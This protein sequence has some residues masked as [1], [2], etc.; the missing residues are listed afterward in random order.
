M[1]ISNIPM[2][3]IFT[4]EDMQVQE[5]HDRPLYFK[6]YIGSMEITRIQVDPGS[7]LSI[8]PRR[9]MEHLSISAHRLST[10]DPNIF[11][12]MLIVP[13]QWGR[14]S[15]GARSGILSRR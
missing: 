9:V 6:G 1:S 7:A 12:L 3:I 13:D 10:T 11:G 5:K 8:M 14:L 15:F 4:S 2:D